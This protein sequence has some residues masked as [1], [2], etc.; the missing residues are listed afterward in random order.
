[1]TRA[2]LAQASDRGLAAMTGVRFA[3]GDATAF[4]LG[5]APADVPELV[6]VNP[7]RRGIGPALA[8][9]LETSS[10][11]WVLYSSCNAVTLARDL[12]HMPSL[13]PV[14]LRLLDMFPQ[15][16]H[17]EVLTLLARAA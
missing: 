6:V 12:E 10:A 14:K 2:E 17:Y 15:T 11:R 4:A 5:S 1:V 3:A 13:R 9:W 7:P 8:A 16:R